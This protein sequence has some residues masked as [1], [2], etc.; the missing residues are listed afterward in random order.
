L[1][2]LY[3][4]S[5]DDD[6]EES[7]GAT[8][9]KT[10]EREDAVTITKGWKWDGSTTL[11]IGF[12]DGSNLLTYSQLHPNKM[13]LG[14]DIHSPGVGTLMKRMEESINNGIYW[15]CPN[16]Y[17]GDGNNN[18]NDASPQE[19]KEEKPYQNVRIYAGDGIKL[20]SYI[21]SNS[22]DDILLT[23][24]DPW[25]NNGHYK[26]RVIQIATLAEMKRVLKP[27]TGR[28]YL[29]TDAVCFHEWTH[30]IFTKVVKEEGGWREVTP[31]PDRREW[32]PVMSK[33]ELKGIEE[34]RF[35]MYQ[36]WESC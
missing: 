25:P 20:L 34:G 5:D 15:K 26:W 32:L 29:A 36:C 4:L 35:T 19:E 28:F 14:A 9:Q 17:N 31:I 2:Q 6:N 33:Y 22:I 16:M 18:E 23:F 30:D 12:G 21:P 3:Q 1:K 11:E 8:E 13:C 24:P 27:N 7:K 10:E